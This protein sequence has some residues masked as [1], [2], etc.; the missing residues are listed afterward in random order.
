MIIDKINKIKNFFS[1][2]ETN[3]SI[4]SLTLFQKKIN[5]FYFSKNKITFYEK[6]NLNKTKNFKLNKFK[7]FTS[8]DLFLNK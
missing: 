4:R 6:K 2:L 5:L 7:K 1:K 3:K 8:S